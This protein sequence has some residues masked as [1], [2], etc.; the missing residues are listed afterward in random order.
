MFSMKW[1]NECLSSKR[2]K[3][4]EKKKQFYKSFKFCRF[5]EKNFSLLRFQIIVNTFKIKDKPM[6]FL[7]SMFEH[8]AQITFEG[9]GRDRR[10]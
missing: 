6:F 1:G 2:R 10:T 9:D 5:D 4:E 7:A 3:N 8:L